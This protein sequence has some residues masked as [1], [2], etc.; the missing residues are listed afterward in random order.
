MPKYSNS[1]KANLYTC[2]EDLITLFEEVIKYFDCTIIC[3][4]RGREAQN[5]AYRDGFSTVQYP[6][7]NHNKL[8]SMATDAV[9][10]VIDWSD[11]NRMRFFAGFVL[12]IAS[13]LYKEGKIQHRVISGFDWDGDTELKDTRFQ[14]A[15]HFQLV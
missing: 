9:P 14:D 13:Q 8:P 7:S 12:G 6:N 11:V 15:P 5:K 3:G 1:S 2:H 4:H 10:Y